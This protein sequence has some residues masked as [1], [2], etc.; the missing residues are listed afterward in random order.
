MSNVNNGNENINNETIQQILSNQE[1]NDICR[2]FNDIYKLIH[3]HNNDTKLK[4]DV[5]KFVLDMLISL[6]RIN[7]NS[8]VNKDLIELVNKDLIELV[9]HYILQYV[10]RIY[11][12][13]Y[14]NH[15][16]TFNS[17]YKI[18]KSTWRKYFDTLVVKHLGTIALTNNLYFIKSI[19]GPYLKKYKVDYWEIRLPNEHKGIDLLNK[20]LTS[21]YTVQIR[22]DN[23][24]F[25][26]YPNA[27]NYRYTIKN[28]D[29]LDDNDIIHIE[30]I[31]KFIDE[32]IDIIDDDDKYNDWWNP[33]IKLNEL[34]YFIKSKHNNLDENIIKA[35]LNYCFSFNVVNENI[36]KFK[37][38]K[39]NESLI[40]YRI[41]NCN[42]EYLNL[43]NLNIT[44]NKKILFNFNIP[45]TV[46]ILDLSYNDIKSM[47]RIKRNH[48][49]KYIITGNEKIIDNPYYKNNI[50]FQ[51]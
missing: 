4:N 9:K 16:H 1:N 20:C 5:Y 51:L 12:Y 30:T 38:K 29:K 48:I 18:N 26:L 27:T 17:K 31:K 32:E 24:T 23:K 19:N 45:E 35:V 6:K 3:D 49:D 15:G 50:L 44:N 39:Y 21:Y 41:N 46:K 47:D 28:E 33:N 2:C 7:M 13:D 8:Y 43:S 25:H 36:R 22:H 34:V 10:F 37:Y 42:N 40:Q 14:K 11:E